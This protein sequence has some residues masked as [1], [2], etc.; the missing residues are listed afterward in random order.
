[1]FSG[2]I[3]SGYLTLDLPKN[4]AGKAGRGL[5]ALWP[6][7]VPCW[8]I[9][10]FKLEIRS[11]KASWEMTKH[12]L[13]RAIRELTDSRASEKETSLG[14]HRG[15][16]LWSPPGSSWCYLSLC[17]LG[18]ARGH[19]KEFGALGLTFFY[20]QNVHTASTGAQDGCLDQEKKN[21][22]KTI[23]SV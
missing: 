2:S 19:T 5:R 11:S 12:P 4:N 14:T 23:P 10:V 6:F 16:V 13:G 7:S 8:V 1:M 21:P 9:G 18:S 20:V 3:W 17:L 15:P 22:I